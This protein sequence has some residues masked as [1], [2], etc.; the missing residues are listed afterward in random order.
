MFLT[1][2]SPLIL[3]VLAGVPS[4]Y[5]VVW[6][7]PICPRGTK[8]LPDGSPCEVDAGV[9]CYRNQ[10]L[11]LHHWLPLT[12]QMALWRKWRHVFTRIVANSETVRGSLVAG[13]IAPV[14]VI[15][16]GVAVRASHGALA[17]RPRL[18]FAG[19]L[20]FEKG[21]DVLLHAFAR[22]V[23]QIPEATLLLL[24]DGPEAGP[25]RSL[26]ARLGLG[27]SVTFRGAIPYTDLEDACSGAWAQVVPSRWAE[28]FGKVA[29]EAMMRGTA[30]IASKRGGLAEIVHDG[31]TG[32]LVP[33][34]D[35]AAWADAM[36][37]VLRDRALATRLGAAG[38]EL[39]TRRY[40]RATYLDRFIMLYHELCQTAGAPYTVNASMEGGYV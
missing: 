38:R 31:R 12:A 7:R 35:V 11:P 28:P 24:G 2:L 16:N 29:V 10:C 14:E 17:Q 15:P 9:A 34:G 3:P 23:P 5:H 13:G 20:V 22:V 37:R 36:L 30:V 32:F 39:A 25:L 26:S 6:Y 1:Q 8:M 4:L 19:R 27:S 40:S 18:A 21:V 33:P